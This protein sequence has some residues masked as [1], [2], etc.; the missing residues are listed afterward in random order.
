MDGLQE[1]IND[2]SILN[3]EDAEYF[4]KINK[5]ANNL[6][7]MDYHNKHYEN[8]LEYIEKN[9]NILSNKLLGAFHELYDIGEDYVLDY[10]INNIEYEC[11][12]Y[13]YNDDYELFQHVEYEKSYK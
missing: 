5:A 2:Y 10:F 13:Y 7:N 11:S 6:Y 12:D 9:V 3:D 4:N 1:A 8:L